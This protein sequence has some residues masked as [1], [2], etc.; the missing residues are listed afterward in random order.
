VKGAGLSFRWQRH[1]GRCYSAADTEAE[2]ETEIF[3]DVIDHASFWDDQT[4]MTDEA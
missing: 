1:R 4:V 3:Q 2:A